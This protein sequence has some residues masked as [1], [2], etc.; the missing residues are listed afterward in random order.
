MF[1]AADL[2]HSHTRADMLADGD[3][4]DVST[5]A[6][7]AGF[8]I[9]V[10]VSRAVWEDCIAW[11]DADTRRK[12]VPQDE[13]GRLWDVVYMARV[14]AARNAQGNRAAFPVY[15][16]PRSGRGQRPRLVTLYLHL[17]HDD[18]GA[19]AMTIMQPRED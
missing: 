4:V 15:R 14:F 12:G 8:K 2:I 5:V 13:S 1:T 10:A 9:P 11:S 16:V 18:D 3:L 6:R 17:G 7:E 19:P